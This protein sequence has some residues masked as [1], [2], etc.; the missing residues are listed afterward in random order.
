M[1][2]FKS[3]HFNIDLYWEKTEKGNLNLFK[4]TMKVKKERNMGNVMLSFKIKC[5]WKQNPHS[6]I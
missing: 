4:M 3:Q 1:I 2:F 6:K 5:I